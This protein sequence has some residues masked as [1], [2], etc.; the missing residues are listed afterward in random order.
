MSLA[1][2]SGLLGV[3]S[4]PLG[5]C[6]GASHRVVEV[7]LVEPSRG[8]RVDETRRLRA[9]GGGEGPLGQRAAGAASLCERCEATSACS[10]AMAAARARES[11]SAAEQGAGGA[12]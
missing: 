5:W 4:G 2:L 7:A 6:R 12:R 10:G 11:E 8:G 3:L 9:T 1:R